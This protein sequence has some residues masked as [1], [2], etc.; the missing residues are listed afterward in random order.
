LPGN[1]RVSVRR[2]DKRQ[3]EDKPSPTC[4]NFNVWYERERTGKESYPPRRVS[5]SNPFVI[6]D[7]V[8]ERARE[9]MPLAPFAHVDEEQE[10]ARGISER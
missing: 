2:D 4:T 6:E 3:G 1:S 7:F 9:E 10:I 8:Y 5:L